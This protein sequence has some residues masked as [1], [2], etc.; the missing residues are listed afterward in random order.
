VGEHLGFRA[1]QK[2]GRLPHGAYISL[3]GKTKM[4]HARKQKDLKN[5][6]LGK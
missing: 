3:K 6:S 4:K 2:Y 1:E 5:K